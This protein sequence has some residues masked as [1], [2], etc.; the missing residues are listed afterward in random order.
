MKAE[1]PSR[2]ALLAKCV[3]SHKSPTASSKMPVRIQRIPA[4][5]E[6]KIR[7]S[8]PMMIAVTEESIPS[9]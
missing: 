9:H 1:A 7:K 8:S 4:D 3:I 5:A 6:G 2:N